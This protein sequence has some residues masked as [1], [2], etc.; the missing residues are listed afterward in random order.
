MILGANGSTL[1]IASAAISNVGQYSVEVTNAGGTVSSP[2]ANLQI[3]LIATGSEGVG[4]DAVD[5]IGSSSQTGDL[6]VVGQASVDSNRGSIIRRNA[7]PIVRRSLL[8]GNRGEK[9]FSTK[10]AVK[11]AGEP[12]HCRVLGGASTWFIY[13][14][15]QDG[16]LRVSTEGSTYDTVLAVYTSPTLDVDYTQLVELAC[17]DNGGSDGKTSVMEFPVEIGTRYYLVVDGANGAQGIVQFAYEISQ[18]PVLS[19]PTW[20]GVDAT[21]GQVDESQENPVVGAGAGVEFR[22]GIGGLPSSAS[23]GYQWR[24]NGIDV[25]GGTNAKL[26]LS[27]LSPADSGAYSV[28]VS[29]FAGTVE[30]QTTRFTVAEPILLLVS[31]DDQTVVRGRSA[32]FAVVPAGAG[33]FEYQ[34][35]L[36]GTALAGLTNSAVVLGDLQSEDAGVY[37]VSISDGISQATASATLTV[38][39]ALLITTQPLGQ[40]VVL[41]EGAQLTVGAQGVEPLRYQWQHNGLDIAGAAAASLELVDAQP[42]QAGEYTVVVSN[43]FGTIVSEPAVVSVRVP[44]SILE[45]PVSQTVV[46]GSRGEFSVSARGTG[47]LS[48][49][50]Q[51]NG[52]DLPGATRPLYAIP[53][54]EQPHAGSY[55]VVV[56]DSEGSVTSQEAILSLLIPPSIT[57]QPSGASVNVGE[58]VTLHVAATGSDPL[59]YQWQLADGAIAGATNAVFEI[60]AASESDVGSYIVIVQ[61]QAGSVVSDPAVVSVQD[62]TVALRIA[63]V[64]RLADLTAELLLEGPAEGLGIVEVSNDLAE[65]SVLATVTVAGG[66]ATHIDSEAQNQDFRFYRVLRAVQLL[67]LTREAGDAVTLEVDGGDGLNVQVQTTE[68]FQ[69][70]TSLSTARVTNAEVT[71]ND[72]NAS[73]KTVQ[74]YRLLVVP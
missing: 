18:A 21:S 10:S 50:W 7:R 15:P 58:T 33:P 70:W 59:Q 39:E 48:Y 45:H 67:G 37:E 16:A 20:F 43:A 19:Q 34:W 31:P 46:S 1:T 4:V 12:N 22:V 5:K 28:E 63:S 65:W 40:S 42:A 8:Q 38:Q 29:T 2:G 51:F 61:N 57:Q 30:S 66:S 32:Y 55:Q 73:G 24:R 52:G 11:D 54:V 35:S 71:F 53:N 60:A 72:P 49:Q 56:S 26:L 74:F 27:S 13:E 17:N 36:D 25:T 3:N 68:D 62:T 41:G 69:Q 23:V 14:P 47:A 64:N 9:L 6:V 44:L